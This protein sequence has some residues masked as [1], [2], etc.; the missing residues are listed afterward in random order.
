MGRQVRRGLHLLQEKRG[1]AASS[2]CCQSAPSTR[3]THHR[4]RR[5]RFPCNPLDPLSNKQRHRAKEKSMIINCCYLR[6]REDAL[7]YFYHRPEAERLRDGHVGEHL[8]IQLDSAVGHHIDQ[9]A[10]RDAVH[11]RRGIDPENPQLAHLALLH[12]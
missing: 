6:L 9:V 8:A 11:S 12:L 5:S 10:V 7:H 1:A 2:S 4:Y 3:P